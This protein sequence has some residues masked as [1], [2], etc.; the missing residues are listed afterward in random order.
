MSLGERLAA[1]AGRWSLPP[2]R[3]ATLACVLG[4]ALLVVASRAKLAK[5]AW[6]HLGRVPRGRF[7]AGVAI[8]AALLSLAYVAVYLRGGPRIIDATTYW[9]QGRSIASGGFGFEV[10]EPSASFRGRFLVYEG[11]RA[12]GIFPPGYPILLAMGFLLGAPLAVGLALAAG[13][14]LAT[15]AL[16]RQITGDAK[17]ARLA[18]ILSIVNAALRYHTADTMA[19]GAAALGVTLALLY[20]LRA[21]DAHARAKDAPPAQPWLVAGLLLGWV[22]STRIASSFAVGAVILYVA[23]SA[24]PRAV[25][26]VV[27]GALPGALLLL[28]AQHAATGH[29]LQFTQTEYY[30]RSDG[31]PGCFRWGFGE[32]I[33]CVVEHADFVAARLPHGYGA[34]EALGVTLRRLHLHA[35][36]VLNGW[37]L[38]LL[39][40]PGFARAGRAAPAVLATVLLHVLAYAPFYFDGNYPGGGARFFADV[41][42]LEHALIAA[43]IASARWAS[44][45]QRALGL[46]GASLVMFGVH[47][48]H[49]HLALA[50]RD[51]GRPMF[52]V[53]ELEQSSV[54]TGLLFVDTDHGFGLGHIP[55]ATVAEGVVV[56]RRRDDD[57]DRLLYDRLGHPPTYAYR[58]SESAPGTSVHPFLPPSAQ[59]LFGRE[60]WRFEAESDWP[61]LAQ[62]Q[63]YAWPRWASGSCASNGR[64]LELVPAGMDARVTIGVPVPREARWIVTPF[65]LRRPGDGSGTLTLRRAN[66]SEALAHWDIAPFS[67]PGCAELPGAQVSVEQG[68][69]R[70]ELAATNGPIALD[71]VVIALPHP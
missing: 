54:R 43:W 46:V 7:I 52:E 32:G 12:Y 11:H 61:P 53:D 27:V 35:S 63:G 23:A 58:F 17:A 36:D 31:P 57:H 10:P 42:P 41:L 50:A 67:L 49:G 24:R 29:W 48:A 30:A 56:A 15:A 20:A 51:N 19:H 1:L 71:K 70:L 47:A 45:E 6:A 55:G 5:E 18:A 62:S 64:V 16:A 34:L 8:A 37:P 28:S 25:L 59:D 60:A 2:D 65:L 26:L 68:E 33:G 14:A 3:A 22:L 38:A 44:F 13:I 66:S 39:V 69:L 9:L 21:R 4:V 40:L